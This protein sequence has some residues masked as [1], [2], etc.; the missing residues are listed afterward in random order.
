MCATMVVNL[1]FI[2]TTGQK[3]KSGGGGSM[4]TA[5]KETECMT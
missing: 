3:E 5:S 4:E 2:R 1:V